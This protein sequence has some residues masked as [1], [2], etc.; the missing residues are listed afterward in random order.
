MTLGAPAPELLEKSLGY[1]FNDK[2]LLDGALSHR[3]AGSRNNERL[4]FLG[5]SVL[6]SVISRQLFDACPDMPEG[7][8][9][10]MRSSLVRGDTLAEIASEL[11]L[12]P[13]LKLGPGERASGGRRRASILADALEAILGAVYRDSDYATV[14]RLILQ[15]WQN[16]LDS[17]PSTDSLKD[18]KTRLQE[19]LQGKSEER[20]EYE[21]YRVT[22]KAH[23]Q[24]FTVIC[25]AADQHCTAT[26]GSRR[27]AE[28]AAATKML[29]QLDA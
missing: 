10:R 25:R 4:E 11:G 14:E 17:L 15:I 5:D 12:G 22:G 9:S 1:Q 29:G 19:L 13:Y 23:A 27:K 24:T 2:R 7:D 28:Q 20:P 3:S 21:V 18:P 26:G 8:L 16:R 6:G